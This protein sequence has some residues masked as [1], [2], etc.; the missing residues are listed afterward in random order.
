MHQRAAHYCTVPGAMFR[1]CGAAGKGLE[2]PPLRGGNSKERSAKHCVRQTRSGLRSQIETSWFVS[3]Y[4]LSPVAHP[5]VSSLTSPAASTPLGLLPHATI[6]GRLAT[7]HCGHPVRMHSAARQ[8]CGAPN[9]VW[10]GFVRK[11]G[12]YRHVPDL[13]SLIV[14][15]GDAALGIVSR[16]MD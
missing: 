3:G 10:R 2:Y 16:L 12:V 14:D 9:R 5:D 15:D 6:G 8:H 7:R 11:P 4:P 1:I 13:T